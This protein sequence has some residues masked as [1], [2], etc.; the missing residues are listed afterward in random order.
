MKHVN[1]A[2]FVPDE[3]CP[4]RCVFCNQKSISGKRERLTVNEVDLA[5][6]AALRSGKTS[7]DSEIAFF[8]G[9]F[10]GIEPSY[11]DELLA[12]AFRYV[13]SGSFKGIRISTRPDYIDEEILAHL[14]AFGVTSIELGCQSMDDRVLAL[15]GRGHT[16]DDTRKACGLIKGYGF[17]LGVQ[18]M[19][20]LFGDT[21]E[22]SLN[23]AKA[24]IKLS[25]ATVRIYPT[26]VLKDTELE[27]LLQNGSY[28]PQSLDSAV[29][30]CSEL[31]RLFES[32]GVR[33]IRLGLHSGGGLDDSLIAGPWH[34][35]FAEL[36]MS[37]LYLNAVLDE[38]E[39]KGIPQGN[40]TINV[41]PSRV[42][43]LAGQKK[44]NIKKLEE[45]GYVVEINQDPKLKE[46][47]VSIDR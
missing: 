22:G 2:L 46:Y 10:T 7:G 5:V 23:T 27:S 18:M 47:E 26:V 17:E 39:R 38:L 33:V 36:C 14:K 40:I 42:S 44:E 16:S 29:S 32:S 25:P 15:N 28:K 35:A 13:K 43:Q 4:H 31:L 8:G 19:T 3:G 20:G 37:R 21:D 1:V 34:P 9:S 30:I 6:E 12:C 24:L 45:I 11:M 41:S